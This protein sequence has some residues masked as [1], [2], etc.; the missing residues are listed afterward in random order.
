MG[1]SLMTLEE[2]KTL[3]VQDLID[4]AGGGH[5]YLWVPAGFNRAGLGMECAHAWGFD[6][7]GEIV[8][9]KPNFGLGAFPRPQH[10]ILLVCRVGQLPFVP[11]NIGS[12]QHWSHT[13]VNGKTPWSGK[14][15]SAKPS[16]ALDLVERASPGPYVELFARQPRMGWDS[17]GWGYEA[18]GEMEGSRGCGN[19]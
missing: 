9:A 8:W 16:A 4:A 18:L 17:W 5:L 3:P 2:I 12:V 15:H 19:P 10:E 14:L 11:R 7:V 6:V 1:Y 13:Y